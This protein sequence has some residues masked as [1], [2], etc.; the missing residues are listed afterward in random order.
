MRM[1]SVIFLA[2]ACNKLD[3]INT[4]SAVSSLRRESTRRLHEICFNVRKIRINNEYTLLGPL[5]NNKSTGQHAENVS[6]HR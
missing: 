5:I 4:G 6:A 2:F 1:A 3:F